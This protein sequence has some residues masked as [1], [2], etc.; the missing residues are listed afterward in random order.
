MWNHKPRAV[1]CRQTPGHYEVRST[2]YPERCLHGVFLRVCQPS[3]WLFPT[4]PQGGRAASVSLTLCRIF[5]LVSCT[6][7][8]C[9]PGHAPALRCFSPGFPLEAT[10][11]FPFPM[12]SCWTGP[13]WG[14]L[15]VT[16][17]GQRGLQQQALTASMSATSISPS[18]DLA[19]CLRPNLRPE[20]QLVRPANTE[21]G[22]KCWPSVVAH[23]HRA[24]AL[25]QGS[26]SPGQARPSENPPRPSSR[27]TESRSK[28]EPVLK[29]H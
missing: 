7:V 13:S 9:E 12:R 29:R 4:K 26:S 10:I 6:A 22:P 5:S 21:M 16:N 28:W 8:A 23:G 15:R 24:S 20:R 19:F 2:A 25:A 1:G 11:A 14:Q 18:V 17:E 27:F 3:A